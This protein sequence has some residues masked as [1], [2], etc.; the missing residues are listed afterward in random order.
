MLVPMGVLPAPRPRAFFRSKRDLLTTLH[1]PQEAQHGGM[2][3]KGKVTGSESTSSGAGNGGSQTAAP[4]LTHWAKHPPAGVCLEVSSQGNISQIYIDRSSHYVVGCKNG[5]G[6]VKV[7][8]GSGGGE[9]VD[10]WRVVADH[11]TVSGDHA[12]LVFLDNRVMVKDLQSKNGTF[13]ND[14]PVS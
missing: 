9:M 2:V 6:D 14:I 4:R 7:G 13:I 12:M 10:E 11:P 8:V 5:G 1:T 3:A